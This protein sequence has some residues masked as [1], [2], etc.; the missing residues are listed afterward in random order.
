MGGGIT[1]NRGE[2]AR[3]CGLCLEAR[4]SRKRVQP[5]NPV[6]KNC[7]PGS[8]R[9]RPVTSVSAARI[10]REMTKKALSAHRKFTIA[11]CVFLLHIA[12]SHF[13]LAKMGRIAGSEIGRFSTSVVKSEIDV[14]VEWES[15]KRS[16]EKKM[17][18]LR[19]IGVA[20]SFPIA[21]IKSLAGCS[22]S[23]LFALQP[24]IAKEI[25]AKTAYRRVWLIANLELLLNSLTIA[26][27]V[28]AAL[29]FFANRLLII[30]CQETT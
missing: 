25:D 3:A 5:R 8:V 2:A 20:L 6:R 13:V 17:K 26:S 9:G 14:A 28:Y 15:T 11:L 4:S 24:L 7:T 19:P 12:A 16:I 21:T 1:P 10:L 18:V 27:L 29:S 22:F 30:K 23:Y